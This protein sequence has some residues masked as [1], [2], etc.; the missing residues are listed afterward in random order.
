[1]SFL[2]KMKM[3]MDPTL[4]KKLDLLL[5]KMYY[6]VSTNTV[7]ITGNVNLKVEGDLRIKTSDRIMI[8]SGT[9][10]YLNCD[11]DENGDPIVY[12]NAIEH[13]SN[14]LDTPF[15]EECKHGPE[16]FHPHNHKCSHAHNHIDIQPCE[17]SQKQCGGNCNG[18]E[19]C[20]KN[21]SNEENIT[22]N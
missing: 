10:L 17:N 22:K 14:L 18:G 2:D 16:S 6:D 3:L 21:K 5:N 20:C 8:N 11:M 7:T 9:K 1:M 15:K 12:K 13:T 4:D 19:G